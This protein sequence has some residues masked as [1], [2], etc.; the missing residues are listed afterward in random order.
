MKKL[1]SRRENRFFMSSSLVA[2]VMVPICANGPATGSPPHLSKSNSTV[3]STQPECLRDG[4]GEHYGSSTTLTGAPE[5]ALS[6]AATP[7]STDIA[8]AREP[9]LCPSGSD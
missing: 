3:I 5:R 1:F 8:P 6:T 9:A 7:H 2:R 4:G